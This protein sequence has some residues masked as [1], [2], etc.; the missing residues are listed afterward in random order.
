[1]RT[2]IVLITCA[3][4]SAATGLLMAAPAQASTTI[5]CSVPKDPNADY[6]P[7]RSIHS[8]YYEAYVSRGG[9][10]DP[11][12]DADADVRMQILAREGATGVVV[13]GV[14]LVYNSGPRQFVQTQIDAVDGAGH[15]RNGAWDYMAL[16]FNPDQAG[17]G[18]TPDVTRW[19]G[20][21]PSNV[22]GLPR[23]ANSPYFKLNL[24]LYNVNAQGLENALPLYVVF[25]P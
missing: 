5:I 14:W 21:S 25:S 9:D 2:S 10:N 3:A 1:M 22:V 4:L 6:C 11:P 8:T 23:G 20:V 24:E 12:S 15:S 16:G 19:P 7:I 18:S 13:E 17:R